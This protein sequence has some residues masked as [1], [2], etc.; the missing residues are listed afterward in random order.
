[1]FNITGILITSSFQALVMD[2]GC[3]AKM[4]MLWVEAEHNMTITFVFFSA[5]M[6]LFFALHM[7]YV[8]WDSYKAGQPSMINNIKEVLT[9]PISCEIMHDP[10]TLVQ[11]GHT[12]S[13]KSLCQ[14]LLNNPM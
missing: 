1:M 6:I 8:H 9:C 5:L 4:S 12:Y 13:H 2:K 3:L 14:W 11:S 7:Y 10:V